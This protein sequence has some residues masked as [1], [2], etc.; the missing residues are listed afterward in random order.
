MA[1]GMFLRYAASHIRLPGIST[2]SA[3]IVRVS[4]FASTHSRN[5]RHTSP[6]CFALMPS[7]TSERSSELLRR[8]FT[9]SPQCSL[10]NSSR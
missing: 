6:A 2:S 3:F 4:R 9:C 5:G 1:P 8:T 7:N 10:L